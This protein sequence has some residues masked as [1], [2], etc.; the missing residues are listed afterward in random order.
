MLQLRPDQNNATTHIYENGETYLVGQM[1]SGKTAV[2]L[3]AAR[4]LKRDGHISR[5]LIITTKAIASNVYPIEVPKWC[6]E[7]SM[8]TLTGTPKQRADMLALG[9]DIVVINF[10]Q[11]EWFFKNKISSSFDMLIVDE[12]TKLA[13]GGLH[14]KKLRK[15]IPQFTTRVVATGTPVSENWTKLFYPMMIVDNGAAFGR[16]KM[17]WLE[18][19]FMTTDFQQRN[20]EVR[21]PDALTRLMAK[22]I[23]ILNTYTDTLP[24]LS[25][26][27]KRSR[28]SD[29]AGAAYVDMLKHMIADGVEA[30]NA[31]VKTGKLQQLANGFLYETDSDL[32]RTYGSPKFYNFIPPSEPTVFVYQFRYELDLLRGFMPDAVIVSEDVAAVQKFTRGDTN[33]ILLHP[34]GAA[35]GIDLTRASR[36]IMVSPIWSRDAT[37]QVIARI[38]RSG[39]KSTCTVE[40]WVSDGTIEEEIVSREAGKASHHE[41]LTRC[42]ARL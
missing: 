22:N 37:Q 21:L 3:T 24:A 39:Q 20:W 18:K 9:T 15:H 23:F 6:S 10:E 33:A 35:H 25:K 40:T 11:I 34:R 17:A 41:L 13:A 29:A 36:M 19:Y 8:V 7:L 31:A 5:V 30:S 12:V 16:N 26:V 38:W 28:M 42:L 2:L 32:V 27:F 14:F 1:G 4:E